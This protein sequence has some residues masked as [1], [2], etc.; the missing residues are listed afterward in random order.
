MLAA[1]ALGSDERFPQVLLAESAG[2]HAVLQ[3]LGFLLG[4]G[5]FQHRFFIVISIALFIIPFVGLIFGGI[6]LAGTATRASGWKKAAVVGMV[7]SLLPFVAMIIGLALG[8]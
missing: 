2:L 1:G 8:D 7:L 4:Y 6:G 3:V 5:E